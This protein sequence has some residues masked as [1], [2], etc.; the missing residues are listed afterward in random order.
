MKN[1]ANS[2]RKTRPSSVARKSPRRPLSTLDKDRLFSIVGVGASA[3][4]LEALT[5]FLGGVPAEARLAFVVIQHLDP[6]IKGML[7]ELLQ[8]ITRMK[9]AQ[10]R[11]NLVVCPGCVYVIPPNKNLSILHGR[12]HLL[13]PIEPRGLRLP[14][15]FFFRSLAV[16]QRERAVGVILSGMGSDGT[17]GCK[18]IKESSG[19]ILVQEPRSAEFDGMPRSAIEAGPADFVA[20]PEVLPRMIVDFVRRMPRLGKSDPPM[21]EKM[22]SAL[23]KVIILLR[24]ST[25]QDFTLYRRSA[26]FRRVERRMG[27]HKLANIAS[28]VRYLQENPQEI[29]ILF[30]ELL[31]GVTSFFRDRLVW[32]KLGEKALP[33]LFAGRPKGCALRAWVAGC[34]TGEEAYS[35][36]ML[37]KERLDRDQALVGSSLQIYA[38]DL[39]RDA[40]DKARLGFYPENIVADVSRARLSRFFVKEETGYRINKEIRGMVVFAPQNL[41]MD[42]PFTKLDI[43]CCRNLLIYLTPELQRRLVPMFHYVLNPGGLLLLGSSESVGTYA[44]LFAPIAAK[45]RIFRRIESAKQ[46]SKLNYPGMFVPVSISRPSS[47]VP[48]LRPPESLQSMADQVLLTRYAPPAVLVNKEGDIVNVSGRTGK[49]LEPAAG[50]ANWNIVAMARE[51]LRYDLANALKKVQKTKGMVT[52]RGVKIGAANDEQAVSIQV[53]ALEQPRELRGLVLVVFT[54]EA[55][56][57]EAPATAVPSGSKNL[58][59][60]NGYLERQLQNARDQMKTNREEMQTTQ[61][62]LKSMNEELQSTNEELQSTNEE[63]TTSKEEMQSL[64]EELQTVNAELQS[65]L[66]E[67]SSS[68]NDMKNL[69]NSTDIATVFLDNDLRVRRFTLQAKTIFK[70]IPGDVGRP[71][72]D[73]ASSLIYP[74]LAMDTKEVLRTLVV[75]EKSIC[76]TDGLW[77]TTR[78]MPYRTLDD[79]I[80]GVVITFANITAAKELEATLRKKHGILERIS[81]RQALDLRPG[82]SLSRSTTARK[83]P[84]RG[85]ARKSPS[86]KR[87]PERSP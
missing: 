64:N 53:Q 17:M 77:F 27:I 87:R 61:E 6:T 15:D 47:A 50:K 22:K 57:R 39:D 60:R 85:V 19:I 54:D 3:G 13:E 11:D 8:R 49:Y 76:T 2:K 63:L 59:A 18:A 81:A 23:D 67:L 28:Y 33:S 48:S 25:G 80:D 5:R 86:R 70:L 7:P 35:L 29:G 51:G 74:D 75:V 84:A 36:A 72:T 78:I 66:D 1:R 55:G 43:L 82:L 69:L 20:R 71:I 44:T 38:T 14:I 68:N 41:I 21:E 42:P 37:F 65:K 12:L 32:E 56:R 30:K 83:N 10:A 9:V 4:G 79:R 24:S 34:S 46:D 62:E 40:I 58:P 45:E 31:I 26:L 16:D 73:L 52:I